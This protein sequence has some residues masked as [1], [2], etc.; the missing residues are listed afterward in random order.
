MTDIIKEIEVIS[1]DIPKSLLAKLCW[2]FPNQFN[3][4]LW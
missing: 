1:V 2:V 3:N 4:R